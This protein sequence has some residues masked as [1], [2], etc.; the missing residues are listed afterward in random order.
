MAVVQEGVELLPNCDL[1][2]MHMPEGRLIRHQRTVRCDKN[3]HI[4]WR[5]RDA[6][7]ASR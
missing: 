2:G 6:A 3:T 7:V 5:R 4:R 1:C